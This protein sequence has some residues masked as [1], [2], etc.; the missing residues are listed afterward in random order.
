M[1]KPSTS[2]DSTSDSTSDAHWM[3][4]AE[5]S[6]MRRISKASAIKLVRRHGWRRQ[7]DNQGHVRA[8]ASIMAITATSFAPTCRRSPLIRLGA[9]L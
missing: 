2:G 4:F 5:L 3:T 9:G 7:R 1:E 8:L 6:E